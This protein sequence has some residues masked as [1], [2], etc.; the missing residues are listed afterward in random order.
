[1]CLD[2][3]I[4]SDHKTLK[5]PVTKSPG[6][7]TYPTSGQPE[8]ATLFQRF[9]AVAAMAPK[10]SLGHS[11]AKRQRQGV[12]IRGQEGPRGSDPNHSEFESN[13]LESIRIDSTFA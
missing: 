7:V 5:T 12:V 13:H 1:V 11:K 2:S 4:D 6:G 9:G 10:K 3:R 8:Q